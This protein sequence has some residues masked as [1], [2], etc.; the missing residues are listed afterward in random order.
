[1]FFMMGDLSLYIE[2]FL[3]KHF[4]HCY[5]YDKL[6]RLIGKRFFSYRNQNEEFLI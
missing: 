6:Y 3:H 4:E 1:M 2:F 5:N